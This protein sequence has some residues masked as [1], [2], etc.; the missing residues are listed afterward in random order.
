MDFQEALEFVLS[1]EGHYSNDP[2]DPGG[3]TKFGIS[4]KQY[5]NLQIADLTRD[6]A[7]EIYRRDYWDAC[8]CD[9]LPRWIRLSVF[10]CA[11]NQGVG[12]AGKILQ[13]LV[14]AAQDGRIGPRTVQATWRHRETLALSYAVERCLLY[15]RSGRFDKFGRGWVHRALA[16]VIRTSQGAIYPR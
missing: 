12:T 9:E 15:A 16:V 7:A 6:Q 1:R 10:D 3:E 11:V 14:G 2:D 8:R 4:K 5:P 13:A